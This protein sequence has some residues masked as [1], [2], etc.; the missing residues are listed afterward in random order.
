MFGKKNWTGTNFLVLKLPR[1]EAILNRVHHKKI[2]KGQHTLGKETAPQPLPEKEI[3]PVEPGSSDNIE[4]SLDEIEHETLALT[5]KHCQWVGVLDYG[6]SKTDKNLFFENLKI[7]AGF[8]SQ[9]LVSCDDGTQKL[10]FCKVFYCDILQDISFELSTED[11]KSF[12]HAKISTAVNSFLKEIGCI[13]TTNWSGNDF[14]GFRSQKL[15]NDLKLQI[16]QAL[17]SHTVKTKNTNHAE[18]INNVAK[19]LHKNAGPTKDL[20]RTSY[21]TYATS[22]GD[23]RSK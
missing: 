4:L 19:T 12:A 17:N 11:G 7:P 13:T 21:K 1:T 20:S 10:V 3:D 14:F 9:R 22:F 15:K 18:I 2:R 23:I 6:D 16:P 5:K 8:V